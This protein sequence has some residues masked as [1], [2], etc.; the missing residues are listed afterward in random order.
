MEAKRIMIDGIELFIEELE[1]FSAPDSVHDAGFSDGVVR[2]TGAQL[3]N[4][5]KPATVI[6]NSLCEVTKD[7]APDE[8][9]LSMQ[10]EIGLNGNTPVLKIVSAE[11]K[12]QLSV[13]FVWKK[14]NGTAH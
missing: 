8:M 11:S 12:F 14:E 13:K 9:E 1:D 2:W 6:L 10:F 3:Q 5:L 7:V 4:A